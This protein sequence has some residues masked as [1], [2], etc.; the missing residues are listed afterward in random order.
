MIQDHQLFKTSLKILLK[1]KSGEYLI[2][3]ATSDAFKGWW[4][5]PGGRIDKT[6]INVDFHKL[7]DREIKEEIGKNVKYKLRPDPVSLSK[8]KFPSG[9]STLYIL[10]EAKYISGKIEISDEHSEYSWA[11]L[12][13]KNIKKKL[14]DSLTTLMNNYFN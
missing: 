7:I 12:N 8:Y 9:G 1:N 6:E 13:K 4:D 14:H 11:K 10:F 3:K 2:M 5:F